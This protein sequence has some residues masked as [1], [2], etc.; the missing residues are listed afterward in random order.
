MKVTIGPYTKTYS[1]YQLARALLF[2]EKRN[3]DG[4]ES[5]MVLKFGDFL[6]GPDDNPSFISKICTWLTERQK[7]KVKIH[8]DS[9]D[10]WSADQTLAYIIHPV[11]VKIKESKL[12]S[13]YVDDEDVPDDL[14]SI[15][16]PP[17]KTDY[18]ID[19]NH[20]ARWDWVLDEMIWTFEQCTIEWED[21]YYS[22][23]FDLKFVKL[24][25][26]NPQ[27][28]YDLV[29]GPEHTGVVNNEG[30]ELHRKRISNGLRLFGKYYHS[31]WV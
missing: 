9:Y 16:A 20:E 25:E 5:D 6:S 17:K 14:K 12:G 1:P 3:S 28:P 10:L 26:T 13:P 24:D 21:F 19:D 23:N 30:L 18:D 2:W 15:S 22:G 27:S 7:R 4:T 31:L 8:I 11:L 29:E